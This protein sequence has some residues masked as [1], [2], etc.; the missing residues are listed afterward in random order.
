MSELIIKKVPSPDQR[1]LPIFEELNEISDQI[2]VRAYS[3]FADRGFS[4]GHELDD[5]LTA[6]REICWPAAEL[7]EEDNEFRARVALAGFDAED[8]DLTATPR[9]II[10]KATRKS[11]Q[12]DHE[13]HDEATVRWSE[14]SSNAVYR[15]IAFPSDV[16]VGAIRVNFDN[17]MLEI[18]APKAGTDETPEEPEAY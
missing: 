2:R 13:S 12:G 7:V 17:G 4:V 16:D 14:F 3:L 9:E 8:I 10:V 6:Q 5:W 15:Q 11:E 1:D 18:E